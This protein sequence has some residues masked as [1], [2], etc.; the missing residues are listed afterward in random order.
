[1]K[2]QED[3]QEQIFYKSLAKQILNSMIG[4][5]SLSNILQKIIQVSRFRPISFFFNFIFRILFI[6]VENSVKLKTY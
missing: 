1:M 3:F 4:H 6:K 2:T 5:T